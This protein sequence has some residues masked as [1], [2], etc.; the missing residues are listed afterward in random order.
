GTVY[1]VINAGITANVFRIATT[2][3]YPPNTNGPCGPAINTSGSQSGVHSV[4]ALG[5]DQQ[6]V[7]FPPGDYKFSS[8]ENIPD[9]RRIHLI[10]EGGARI[11][12]IHG[13]FGA[14]FAPPNCANQINSFAYINYQGQNWN[15]ITCKTPADAAKFPAGLWIMI[16]CLNVQDAWRT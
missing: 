12:R 8:N 9:T 13:V 4:R 1:Y 10:G 11:R 5:Y 6:K 7:F 3:A 14:A 15:Q 16:G 2:S